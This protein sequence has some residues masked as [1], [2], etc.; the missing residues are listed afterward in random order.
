MKL[1]ELSIG[2][3]EVIETYHRG[4][5]LCDSYERLKPLVDAALPISIIVKMCSDLGSDECVRGRVKNII[6][7]GSKPKA[8]W[9][10][11]H[12]E[13]LGLLPL[14][15]DH[16]KFRL[17]NLIASATFWRGCRPANKH[18]PSTGECRIDT[19]GAE[20]EA[21]VE[22][23][24]KNIGVDYSKHDRDK[25][26]GS[27]IIIYDAIFG[28]LLNLLGYK[29]GAKKANSQVVPDYIQS[30]LLTLEDLSSGRKELK[31]AREILRDFIFT[32][33]FFR[34]KYRGDGNKGDGRVSLIGMNDRVSAERHANVIAEIAN[35]SFNPAISFSSRIN[36]TSD[37]SSVLVLDEKV[38][39]RELADTF[40]GRIAEVIIQNQ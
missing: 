23:L 21:V 36:N 30:A 20:Q 6:Q 34:Y 5:E 1:S 14:G 39:A 31:F 13:N 37:N 2:R 38:E 35:L 17:I 4:P 26:R 12:L 22:D 28:R 15:A 32:L 29:N 16:P 40:R 33:L 19:Q 27:R 7:K 25:D 3:K 24:L 8:L 9:G 11:E 18:Q 10:V